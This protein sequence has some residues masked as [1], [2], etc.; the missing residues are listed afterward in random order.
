MTSAASG[1]RVLAYQQSA[2]GTKL[3]GNRL[4]PKRLGI[5]N[6]HEHLA[7]FAIVVEPSLSFSS[8]GELLMSDAAVWMHQCHR[9]HLAARTERFLLFNLCRIERHMHCPKHLAIELSEFGFNVHF[10]CY[11]PL[12]DVSCE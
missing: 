9:Q 8:G 6:D 3:A 2:D 11:H 12:L 7:D 5:R 1:N 4:C 10:G